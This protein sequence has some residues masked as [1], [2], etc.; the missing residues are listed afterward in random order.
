MCHK[1]RYSDV[2]IV[3][4]SGCYSQNAQSQIRGGSEKGYQ[5]GE[6]SES[7]VVWAVVKGFGDVLPTKER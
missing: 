3:S 1:C 6:G 4:T 7:Q 5:V 2:G